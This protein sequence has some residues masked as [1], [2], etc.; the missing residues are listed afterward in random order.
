MRDFACP[1]FDDGRAS[2][3][4][5]SGGDV[6]TQ[7]QLRSSGLEVHVVTV[8]R[9]TNFVNANQLEKRLQQVVTHWS[10]QVVHLFTPSCVCVCMI[11]V[12]V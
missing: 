2:P 4:R 8:Y 6:V 12:R 9:T 5:V 3:R 7:T 10:H 11:R 1:L